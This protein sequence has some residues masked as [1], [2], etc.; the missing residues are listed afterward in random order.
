MGCC[1]HLQ[2]FHPSPSKF[3]LSNQSQLNLSLQ[4]WKIHF[5]NFN[6]YYLWLTWAY[7][8]VQLF[9]GQCQRGC[10]IDPRPNEIQQS[11][12]KYMY[13]YYHCV[14]EH[15]W[16]FVSVSNMKKNME[17]KDHSLRHKFYLY[18]HERLKQNCFTINSQ[19]KKMSQF[20][21]F[22]KIQATSQ[23]RCLVWG[24]NPN[25]NKVPLLI[26]YYMHKYPGAGVWGWGW[27]WGWGGG[28]AGGGGW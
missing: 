26:V 11:Q 4:Q 17:K 23:S 13:M 18:N 21:A 25:N 20:C 2:T 15:L 28:G 12:W 1:L 8:V 7:M 10:K 6:I 9:K 24:N 22:T 19:T 3:I 5:S 16:L 14:C 27:G